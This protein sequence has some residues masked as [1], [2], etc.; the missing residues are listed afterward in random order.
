MHTAV[1]MDVVESRSLCY[2][3]LVHN[4][5]RLW[6]ALRVRVCVCVCERACGCDRGQYR[7]SPNP[8]TQNPKPKTQNPKPENCLLFFGCGCAAG[9]RLWHFQTEK[10]PLAANA[11]VLQ[12]PLLFH[13]KQFVTIQIGL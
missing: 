12:T 13:S 11:Q 5:K 4:G 2:R 1:Q 6:M 9:V 8:K 10:Q 7:S 3:A